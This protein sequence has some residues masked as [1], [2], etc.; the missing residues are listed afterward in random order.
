MYKEAISFI[1]D[2][3][4]SRDDKNKDADLTALSDGLATIHE[5]RSAVVMG[6]TE[7]ASVLEGNVK[8]AIEKINNIAVLNS[9]NEF[10]DESTDVYT[11]TTALGTE[12]WGI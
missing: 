10:F 11:A 4:I 1:K 3:T 6:D 8:E 5:Y 9:C 2:F 7:S 12:L